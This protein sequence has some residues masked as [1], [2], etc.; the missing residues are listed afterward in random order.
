VILIIFEAA[1]LPIA[2]V[3][4]IIA[5]M[6]YNSRRAERLTAFRNSTESHPLHLND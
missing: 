5:V 1:F 6:R 4:G 3:V 2:I